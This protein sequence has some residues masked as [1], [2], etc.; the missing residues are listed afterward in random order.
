[1]SVGELLKRAFTIGLIAS[2]II[3]TISLICYV[4]GMSLLAIDTSFIAAI[5]L[6]L[7]PMSSLIAV[8]IELARR[9]D[10]RGLITVIVVVCIVAI[11]MLIALLLY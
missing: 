7:T 6:L 2:L 4:L 10:Y 1:M 11:S 3:F 9:G 5:V 8:A